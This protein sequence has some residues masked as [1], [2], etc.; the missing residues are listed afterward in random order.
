M[1]L[2]QNIREIIFVSEAVVIYVFL[3]MQALNGNKAYSAFHI[4]CIILDSHFLLPT[5]S[6]VNLNATRMAEKT[7]DG[8]IRVFICTYHA[9][10]PPN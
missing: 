7:F 10:R 5:P 8:A 6:A 2:W 4:L 9:I 1:L 3:I